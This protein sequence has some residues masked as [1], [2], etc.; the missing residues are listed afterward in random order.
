MSALCGAIILAAGQSR[1]MGFNKLLAEYRGKPMV[2]HVADA[3]E[4]AGLPAIAVLGH[5]EQETRAALAGRQIG[6]VLADHHAEGMG[7][8]VAAGIKAVP[9]EWQAAI[10]CLG[11]MPLIAPDLLRQLAERAAPSALV[12]P[13]FNG[14]RGNPVLWGRDHFDKLATLHG[15]VGARTLFEPLAAQLSQLPWHDDTVV[16]DF[17]EPS[18]LLSI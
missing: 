7:H 10:V 14:R 11:D 5:Q 17:D 9:S 4:T 1:R 13:T 2:A 15:D 12:I 18:S 3:I 16:R 6:F 8:S